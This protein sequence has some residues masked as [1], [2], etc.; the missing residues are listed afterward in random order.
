MTQAATRTITDVRV[1]HGR[2]N[3]RPDVSAALI[4][5]LGLGYVLAVGYAMVALTYDIWGA[6]VAAPVIAAL[7]VPLLRRL[8]RHDPVL[9]RIAAVGLALKGAGTVARYWVAFTA[10][11]GVADAQR[12]HEAGLVKAAA[13]R[14]GDFGLLGIFPRGQG[15]AFVEH[16]TGSLYAVVGG[17]KLAGFLWFAAL[18]YVGVLLCLKA[19]TLFPDTFSV[20]RYAWLC[21]VSPSLVFWP[22]SIGKES[23]MLLSLGLLAMGAARLYA[24]RQ[25]LRPLLFVAAGIGGAVLVRPHIAALWTIVVVIATLWHLVGRR[26]E[27]RNSRAAAIVALGL[28]VVGLVVVGRVAL[29]FLTEQE[30]TEP[31]TTQLSDIFERTTERTAG[32]GSQFRPPSIDSPLDYPYAIVRTITRPLLIE[33]STLTTLLPAIE[34]TALIALAVLGYRRLAALPGVLR[35]SPY[36]VLHLFLA[37]IT[38]LAYTSFSNLAILVRQRSLLMPS[39]LLLL[40]VRPRVR[41]GEG[42]R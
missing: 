10:Y 34:T 42:R 32:G 9:W 26:T 30:T 16:L 15:T 41:P 25:F 37:A 19:A 36:A 18:G 8:F 21:A 12:Y 22:S 6:L 3:G 39:L 5:A 27:R 24:T 28:G 14:D 31:V 20:H 2:A 35:R 13:I 40:C 1:R 11:G 38:A 23:W 4:V 33:A 17:S 29:R 7:F